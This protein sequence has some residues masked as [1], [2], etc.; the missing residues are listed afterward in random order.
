MRYLRTVLGEDRPSRQGI[1]RGSGGRPHGIRQG[2]EDHGDVVLKRIAYD[3]ERAI[4]DLRALPVPTQ[5]ADGLAS[6]LRMG[7]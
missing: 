3:V 1:G 5:I 2:R 7:R 6:I 4:R